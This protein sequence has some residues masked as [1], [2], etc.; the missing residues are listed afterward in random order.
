MEYLAVLNEVRIYTENCS[1]DPRLYG[2]PIITYNNAAL[3]LEKINKMYDRWRHD[4]LEFT[5]QY[6]LHYTL[7]LIETSIAGG[8][9]MLYILES[10]EETF[11]KMMDDAKRDLDDG[12]TVSNCE[13][14][15]S[16]INNV[17]I[18]NNAMLAEVYRIVDHNDNKKRIK[19]MRDSL[20][21]MA[22]GLDEECRS[23]LAKVAS[24]HKYL[25]N[26]HFEIMHRLSDVIRD[27]RDKIKLISVLSVPCEAYIMAFQ[28]GDLARQIADTRSSSACS[29]GK[30]ESNGPSRSRRWPGGSRKH[31][32]KRKHQT[33]N[34]KGR[35][36]GTA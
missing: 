31:K 18:F 30:N 4:K 14:F 6:K 34:H 25:E 10:G 26:Y 33:K 19:S 22:S 17:V 29:K 36:R 27:H 23:D 21:D 35:G 16:A 8:N 1:A 24:R 15:L 13:A 5:L 28:N 20:R 12:I 2:D 9:A 32:H 11:V 7:A 3:A